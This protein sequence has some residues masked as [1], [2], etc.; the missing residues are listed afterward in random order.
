MCAAITKFR[1]TQ[2]DHNDQALTYEAAFQEGTL[3]YADS[4]TSNELTTETRNV[5]FYCTYDADTA[6][7]TTS[8]EIDGNAWRDIDSADHLDTFLVSVFIAG[9][10]PQE[11]LNALADALGV[12]EPGRVL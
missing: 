11:I 12:D 6:P 5:I 9:E 10:E 3:V 1:I 7:K 2:Y 8:L 4:Q